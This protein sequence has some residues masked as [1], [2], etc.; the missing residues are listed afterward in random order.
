MQHEFYKFLILVEERYFSKAAQKLNISQPALTQ[1][2][3]NLEKELGTQLLNRS[4]HGIQLTETGEIVYSYAR[5]MRLVKQNMEYELNVET[6]SL[7]VLKLGIIDSL[8]EALLSNRNA[9]AD[10]KLQ[11]T[12]DNSRR[13]LKELGYDRLDLVIST[14]PRNKLSDEFRVE[15]IGNERFVLV[16]APKL[17]KSVTKDMRS[18]GKIPG[19]LAYDKSSNTYLLINHYLSE[20]KLR[21]LEEFHSTSP[22]LIKKMALHGEG[23]ALLPASMV[24]K[25][26]GNGKLLRHK[27]INFKRPITAVTLSGKYYNDTMRKVVE[28]IRKELH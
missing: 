24:K 8:G 26:L 14:K 19:F 4:H 17:A 6:K 12:V 9:V 1:A 28:T 23:T 10:A 13:L 20:C 22:D 7:R 2:I 16:T 27:N 15:H 5:D 21:P 18:E 11:V 25:E 3:N